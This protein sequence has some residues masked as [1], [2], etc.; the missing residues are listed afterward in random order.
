ML[1]I[2]T[3]SAHQAGAN[4][5]KEAQERSVQSVPDQYSTKYLIKIDFQN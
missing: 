2:Q 5:D 4:W 3:N 1:Q